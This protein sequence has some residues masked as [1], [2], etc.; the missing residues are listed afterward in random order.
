MDTEVF[1]LN[2]FVRLVLVVHDLVEAM[3]G[4]CKDSVVG[5]LV[6]IGVALLGLLD[7]IHCLTLATLPDDVVLQ[8]DVGLLG[9]M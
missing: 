2:G 1:L 3:V 7:D 8:D 4:P 5:V 6:R 9:Q